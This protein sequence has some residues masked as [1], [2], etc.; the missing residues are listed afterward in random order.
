MKTL[1]V[2]ASKHGCTE[3]C[4]K[5]L[6][7]KLTGEIELVRLG[8]G[9]APDPKMYDRIIIGGS[10]HVGKVQ[11]EVLDFSAGH[12]EVL[13]QKK[14]GLFIC[15]GDLTRVETQMKDAFPEPLYSHAIAREHFGHAYDFKKMN[16]LER[17]AIKVIAKTSESVENILV[18]NLER[19]AAAME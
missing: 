14:V 4:A 19:F 8:K 15:C 16:F 10:I 11:K 6:A 2:Y 1:L 18:G 7:E 3:K 9:K 17:T 12:M 13:L 5:M